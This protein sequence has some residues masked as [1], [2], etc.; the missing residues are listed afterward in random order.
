M[1]M[2]GKLLIAHPNVPSESPWHKTVIFLYDDNPKGHLGVVL[3]VRSKYTIK[4]LCNQKGILY[5][6]GLRPI[7]TGGPVSQESIVMLHTN[8]WQS[9]N[10]MNVGAQLRLSSDE[11]MFQKIAY[12]D[13]PAYYRVFG[14]ISA[15]TAGQLDME[16]QGRF[17]YT[18][19]NSWLIADA[20]DELVFEYSDEEQ[21]TQALEAATNQAVAGMLV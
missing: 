20:N 21:W 15:W 11:L 4:D 14:G 9:T 8:E 16:L 13:V 6:N 19:S 7:Y 5:D 12:G 1:S 2:R 3:N 10:T 18:A 17:P